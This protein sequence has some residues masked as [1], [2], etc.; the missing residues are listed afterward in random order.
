[1]SAADLPAVA[2]VLASRDGALHLPDA[3]ASLAAQ[4]LAPAEVLLVDDGSV[5]GTPALFEAF[6]RE[7]RQAR[8]LRAGGVGPAGARDLGIREAR[9]PLIAIQDDDDLSR[10]E[11]LAREAAFLAAH[12]EVGLVGSAADVIDPDGRAIEPYP[13]PTT[14][15]GI[16][17]MLRRAPPFVHGSVMMWRDAYLAAGGYRAAFA[18]SED[19]D[20]YLRLAE[21]TALAN[22]PERLYAWRRHPGNTFARRRGE[23]LMYAALAR[24][25]A[26][27]RAHGHG[28]SLAAW[29]AAGG[30]E[31]FLARH[32]LGP[33]LARCWG[34]GLVREGRVRSG[35]RVLARAFGAASL[36]PGAL[37]WWLLSFVVAL[38]PRAVRAAE[39]HA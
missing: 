4:T 15:A 3:L 12:P 30:A 39:D 10:P 35:R 24:A 36:M 29:S 17:R 1:M 21:R 14:P 20:L 22:L 8:V 18:V 7:H 33:R 38:T 26:W 27:E 9:S 28:D 32:P 2:V 25:L 6:A 5:D 16:R 37:A 11:R 23:H 13:V 31:A 19:F 34:E